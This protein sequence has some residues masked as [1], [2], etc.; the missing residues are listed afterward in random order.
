MFCSMWEVQNTH[1]IWPIS[2]SQGLTPF[3]PIRDSTHEHG[4]VHASSLDLRFCQINKG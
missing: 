4:F 1:G 2:L 3:R